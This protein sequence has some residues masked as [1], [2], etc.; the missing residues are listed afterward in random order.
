MQ[1]L[2]VVII[3]HNEEENILRCIHSVRELADEIL[4]VDS[5]ST[6]RTVEICGTSGCRVIS[7]PFEGYGQQKQFGVEQA[8]NNWILSLD[9]DEVVTPELKQEITA[10]M[11]QEGI[12]HGGYQIPFS[13]FYMGRILSHSGTG[14]E[15]HLRLFDRTRGGF[16]MVKVHEGVE[17]NSSVGRL[18]G[19]IIH[20]S[21][22]D[23]FHHLEK[24]N[25]Y[26][27]QAAQGYTARGKKF[28][29]ALIPFRFPVGFFVNYF[30]KLGILDGYPGFYYSFLAAFYSSV[31]AAKT[32]EMQEKK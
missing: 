5:F 16:T 15:F 29:K 18:K 1:Q 2:S 20:Y 8:G 12:L 11:H 6:D 14:N 19:K 25:T 13:L 32:I 31:K 26:T 30:I 27:S 10:I 7:H 21:Y 3:T 24:I 22:R 28:S 23:L 4:V 9:A 17:T